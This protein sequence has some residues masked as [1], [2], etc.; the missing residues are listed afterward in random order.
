VGFLLSD[1]NS[2]EGLVDAV[3]RSITQ[4]VN[5]RAALVVTKDMFEISQTIS[6]LF[7]ALSDAFCSLSV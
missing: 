5:R 7:Y 1:Y 3:E 2:K 6:A 4:R